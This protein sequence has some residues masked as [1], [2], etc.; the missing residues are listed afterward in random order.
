[1]TANSLIPCVS[2]ATEFDELLNKDLSP[3]LVRDAEA[4][5]ELHEFRP[6]QL[7]MAV[8]GANQQ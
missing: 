7:D 3:L 5:A 4:L 2:V 6:R 1:M 8:S